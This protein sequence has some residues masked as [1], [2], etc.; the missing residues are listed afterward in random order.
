[1]TDKKDQF[2]PVEQDGNK[3]HGIR[4][5]VE[6][7]GSEKVSIGTLQPYEEGRPLSHE[8]VRLSKRDEGDPAY[9]VK[10]LYKRASGK[11]PA[12]VATPTYRKNFNAVFGKKKN[13][14]N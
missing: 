2:L 13:L 1:M 12:K 11:G 7:D 14:L 3:I 9:D 6:E 8:L 10:S 4:R 5:V